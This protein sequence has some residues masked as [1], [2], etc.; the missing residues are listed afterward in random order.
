M[1]RTMICSTPNTPLRNPAVDWGRLA[2]V[3]LGRTLRAIDLEGARAGGS[4][5]ATQ[6]EKFRHTPGG[7]TR[8]VDDKLKQ[9]VSASLRAYQDGEETLAARQRIVLD[10]L[11]SVPPG[12]TGRIR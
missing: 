6:I 1:S 2:R 3:A 5:L 11:N 8:D 12:R 7:R 10:Y 4:T 9:M